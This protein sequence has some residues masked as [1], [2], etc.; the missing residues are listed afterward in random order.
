[1]SVATKENVSIMLLIRLCLCNDSC[2]TN[3]NDGSGC[4]T[5]NLISKHERMGT[6]IRK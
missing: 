3:N 4:I 2:E 6:R 5:T 1:M